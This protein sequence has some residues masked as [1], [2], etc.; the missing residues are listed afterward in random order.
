MFHLRPGPI[1]YLY[2]TKGMMEKAVFGLKYWAEMR[3]KFHGKSAAQVIIR[4]HFQ[5]GFSVVPGSS[6]PKH[7]QENIEVF[8]FE[9]SPEK[10]ARWL[11]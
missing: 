9:L 2:S 4:W 10:M 8:D 1:L 5:N 6:N 3:S 7:I 11:P